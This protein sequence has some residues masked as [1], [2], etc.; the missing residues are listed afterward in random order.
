M[1]FTW[2]MPSSCFQLKHKKKDMLDADVTFALHAVVLE[3]AVLQVTCLRFGTIVTFRSFYHIAWVLV[4]LS[5]LSVVFLS[6]QS[7][8]FLEMERAVWNILSLQIDETW[9]MCVGGSGNT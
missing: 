9:H 2:Q 8:G 1:D 5:K 4:S 6:R 7:A 3:S